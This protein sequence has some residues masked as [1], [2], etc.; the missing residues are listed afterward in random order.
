VPALRTLARPADK[1][2]I[3]RR[4]RTVRPESGRRWGRMSA[5]QMVCHL[6]DSFRAVI[7]QR[8]VSQVDSLLHRTVVKWLALYLPVPWPSGIPTRPELDQVLGGTCP[9]AFDSD[10]A[11]LEALMEQFTAPDVSALRCPHPTMGRLSDVAWLRWGYL[12]MDHHLRQFGA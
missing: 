3:L 1:T 6:C 10:V 9:T 12:H 4:L 11:Q 5:H 7:G 2:E 8:P